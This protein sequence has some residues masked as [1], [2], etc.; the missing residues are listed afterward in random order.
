MKKFADGRVPVPLANQVKAFNTLGSV[1]IKLE[2]GRVFYNEGWSDEKVA[3]DAK[4]SVNHAAVIRRKNFGSLAKQPEVKKRVSLRSDLGVLRSDV[5]D[6]T[7]N[8]KILISE[9]KSLWKL[10][11][12]KTSA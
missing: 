11:E 1:L 9:V 7:N 6:N 4:I 3:E 2:D 12:E 8:I 5:D 10:L